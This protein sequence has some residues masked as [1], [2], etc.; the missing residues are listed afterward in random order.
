MLLR[1]A[2]EDFSQSRSSSRKAIPGT[3]EFCGLCLAF[4]KMSARDAALLMAAGALLELPSLMRAGSRKTKQ[5][6]STFY[7]NRLRHAANRSLSYGAIYAIHA[8]S[9]W[10]FR[11]AIQRAGLHRLRNLRWLLAALCSASTQ[12]VLPDPLPGIVCALMVPRSLGHLL[13]ERFPSLRH[14]PLI[15]V[16]VVIAVAMN[17]QLWTR[18]HLMPPRWREIMMN[19]AGMNG[20]ED[21]VMHRSETREVIPCDAPELG[22]HPSES[23][24]QSAFGALRR[25]TDRLL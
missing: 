25:G 20:R 9:A 18:F 2:N 6:G 16:W 19:A 21:S 4:P 22:L 7:I 15:W 12:L 13:M 8:S 10:L 14:I 24:T 1:C 23:C 17:L 3:A 11:I 5:A